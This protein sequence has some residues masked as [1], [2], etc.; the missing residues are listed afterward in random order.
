MYSRYTIGRAKLG[1]EY[2]WLFEGRTIRESGLPVPSSWHAA[3]LIHLALA[4][5]PHVPVVGLA[6]EEV[7]VH[8]RKAH[9]ALLA[10]PLS[11]FAFAFTLAGMGKGTLHVSPSQAR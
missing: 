3:A 4:H 10:L 5:E 2:R 6:D 11:T 1:R 8:L 7:H 9:E